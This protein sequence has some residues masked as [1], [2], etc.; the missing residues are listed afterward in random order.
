MAAALAIGLAFYGLLLGTYFL[1]Q[2][3]QGVIF[4]QKADDRFAAS[5]SGFDSG[6]HFPGPQLHGEAVFLQQLCGPLL[7]IVFM[8]SALRASP[9]IQAQLFQ[10]GTVF[11]DGLIGD[12]AGHN[13]HNSL[14]I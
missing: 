4:S 9:D 2:A 13:D 12:L 10:L 3:G 7:G 1:T 14:F 5:P 6:G 8:V 11:V